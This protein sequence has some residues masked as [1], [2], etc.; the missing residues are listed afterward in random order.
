MQGCVCV[1]VMLFVCFSKKVLGQEYSSVK[2]QFLGS[3]KVHGIF[4]A[5]NNAAM[6]SSGWD[7]L[8][9]RGSWM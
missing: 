5:L 2:S 1:C 6:S 9:C 8:W 3:A 4:R 7:G